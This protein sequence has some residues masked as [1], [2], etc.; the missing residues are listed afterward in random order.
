MKKQILFVIIIVFCLPLLTLLINLQ[1]FGFNLNWYQR[2]FARLDVYQKY[3]AVRVEQ[4]TENLFAYL[5][6]RGGL[7]ADYYS[8]REQLHLA[9]IKSLLELAYW[10]SLIATVIFFAAIF[11]SLLIFRTRQVIGMIFL[12]NVISLA[13]LLLLL[14]ASLFDFH[15]LFIGFHHLAFTNDNWLLNPDYESLIVIFPPQLFF[16]LTKRIVGYCLLEMF[17]LF[18]LIAALPAARRDQADE[19]DDQS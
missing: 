8:R 17:L 16:D 19:T 12:A 5:Q 3:N 13:L 7:K 2:E 15:R 1:V 10:L 9:D 11:W 14:L 4:Q 18:A 6:G